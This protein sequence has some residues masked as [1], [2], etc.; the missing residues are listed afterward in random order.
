[1][2]TKLEQWVTRW[3]E[4]R[5]E[6]W[7]L[8][9]AQDDPRSVYEARRRRLICKLNGHSWW[10]PEIHFAEG[11]GIF[12]C[13]RCYPHIESQREIIAYNPFVFRSDP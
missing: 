12:E 2:R 13:G 1:M 11:W 5:R 9:N 3:H 8:P 6:R 7:I 10:V 4:R